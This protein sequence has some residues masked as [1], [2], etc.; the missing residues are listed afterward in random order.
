MI[1]ALSKKIRPKLNQVSM[2]DLVLAV[3][4]T[5]LFTLAYAQSPLYSSNQNQYFL[6]GLAQ[7]GVGYLDQDWL[8]NTLDP[9]PVFSRLVALTQQIFSWPPI[10]YLYY[11]VLAGV[12]LFSLAGIGFQIYPEKRSRSHQGMFFTL[13]IGL[14]SAT[15]S[16]VAVRLGGGSWAFL[17]DGGVA[18][19]RLLGNVL[20]PSAFG[21]LLLLS[22]DRFLRKKYV[23]AIFLLVL[24]PTF[25]PTYLLSAAVL[26]CIYMGITFFEKNEIK[27]PLAL[28][29]GALAGVI[30]ILIH[31]VTTFGGTEVWL[32]QKSRQILVNFRIPHHA[33]PGEWLDG[34]VILKITLI[35]LGL[36]LVRKTRLFQVLF[37]PF[38]V[39]I[40][41]T[42]IQ[43]YLPS[44]TLAL[45]F[46]WRLS[47]WV[48]PISVAV[49]ALRI[50]DSGWSWIGS[51]IS[52]NLIL[53]ISV[54]TGVI[55][56]GL[57]LSKSI[58][59]YQTR[60]NSGDRAMMTYVRANKSSS[61]VYLI[62]LDMQ[63]FRLETEAPAY[64]EFKSIPYKDVELLEWHRRVR[65][66]GNF[67]RVPQKIDGCIQAN[68][69]LAQ[70]VT[71][72][73]LPYDHVAAP[74]PNLE[75]LFP[76]LDY[77]VYKI[78]A[79]A[80]PIRDSQSPTE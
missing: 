22:I 5:L 78:I 51:K 32:A 64:I 29:F 69:F 73:I 24:T 44:D 42:I 74:C 9:T 52:S 18:G 66:T 67:Y 19:Q 41:G 3:G 39:I 57:G 16:Y 33:V 13:L 59:E 15:V 26:T 21:V 49:I 46:P 76:T 53:V 10:F 54:V 23:G 47:T 75:L 31:A 1:N 11:T 38:L 56:A 55:L 28:G 25:H 7:A 50:V 14:Q 34:A 8:A 79:G 72:L 45:L 36:F 6:H 2:R 30:P 60:K 80:W 27:T 58:V 70:G 17:F 43:V 20:Q 65:E 77:E 62:P 63:D 48:V 37:W 4:I 12:Y 40:F 35:G 71:H 68:N 61:E